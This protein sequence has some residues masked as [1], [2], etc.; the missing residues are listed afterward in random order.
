MNDIK[1]IKIVYKKHKGYSI[2]INGGS[3]LFKYC[4]PTQLI[5]KLTNHYLSKGNR[6]T[7]DEYK[8]LLIKLIDLEKGEQQWMILK[9]SKVK[10][11]IQ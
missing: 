7:F 10:K 8:D 5:L 4:T 9:L 6:F 3:K 1:R 2:K 11:A